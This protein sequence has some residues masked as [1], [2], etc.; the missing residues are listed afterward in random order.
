MTGRE[1]GFPGLQHTHTKHFREIGLFCISY[2]AFIRSA[3]QQKSSTPAR[4]AAGGSKCPRGPRSAWSAASTFVTSLN[5]NPLLPSRTAQIHTNNLQTK[6]RLQHRR[7]EVRLTSPGRA[8]NPER[9]QTLEQSPEE[10]LETS[11]S[12]CTAQE[13]KEVMLSF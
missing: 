10:H 3:A 4:F 1:V 5:F 6:S 9:T 11:L 13:S 2:A 12:T 8:F 7:H